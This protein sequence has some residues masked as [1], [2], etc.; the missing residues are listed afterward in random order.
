MQWL[1]AGG[2]CGLLVLI[3]AWGSRRKCSR[4]GASNIAIS[5]TWAEQAKHAYTCH[6]CQQ[7]QDTF[8][9]HV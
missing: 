4:C 8:G 5:R 3:A 6:R 2:F 9:N 7:R 1:L